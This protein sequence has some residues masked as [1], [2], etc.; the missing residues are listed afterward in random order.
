MIRPHVM[1]EQEKFGFLVFVTDLRWAFPEPLQLYLSSPLGTWQEGRGL[2][3]P[4]VPRAQN[5]T[6]RKAG[7]DADR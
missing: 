1:A 3:R 5:S 2:A 4:S 6:S 7:V